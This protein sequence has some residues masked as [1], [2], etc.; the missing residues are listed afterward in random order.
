[1]GNRKTLS[2]QYGDSIIRFHPEYSPHRKTVEIAVEA[3]GDVI[4]TAPDGCADEKLI[5]VVSK[6]AKWITQQI[7]LMKDIRFQKVQR[8]LVSGESLLYLGRNYRLD[9]KIDSSLRIP[10]ISLS[11][12][13]FHVLTMNAD[14]D[15]LRPFLVD[16]YKRKAGLKIHERIDYFATKLSVQPSGIV[17][18]EQKKRW[19]SCTT[20]NVLN[21]NW[22]CILAPAHI[23]D[24]IIAHELC[25]LIEKNHS[26]KFWSL[27]RAV[28]PDYEMR[29]KWLMEN[30]VKMDI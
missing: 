24:Y 7:F 2:F 19:G 12:G 8:E 27:L 13:V 11:N 26:I 3:P 16:W 4:V 10:S 23:L 21:F 18:K 9:L 5:Q 6:K 28:M 29:K 15:Y 20:G 25:H 14:H 22:R 30:G 17:I 1:M